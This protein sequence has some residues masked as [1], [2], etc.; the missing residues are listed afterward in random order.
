MLYLP[1]IPSHTSW[2]SNSIL[3]HHVSEVSRLLELL[4]GP[5]LLTQSFIRYALSLYYV[6]GPVHTRDKRLI[7]CYKT[8]TRVD[9]DH[10]EQIKKKKVISSNRRTDDQEPHKYVHMIQEKWYLNQDRKNKE[11]LAWWEA[12]PKRGRG[13]GGMCPG[14]GP[15]G[16][17]QASEHSQG[18]E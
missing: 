3:L 9:R 15:H 18:M 13:R 17:P 14:H 11:M 7:P 6:A 5:P 10:M 4:D 2:F 8:A 12:H 1:L 16:R